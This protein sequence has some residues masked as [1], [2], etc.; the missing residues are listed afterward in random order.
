MISTQYPFAT[1]IETPSAATRGTDRLVPIGRPQTR[2][3]NQAAFD[4]AC[5]ELMRVVE[6]DFTPALVVGVRTGGL[7]VA[8]AM[9]RAA[10]TRPTVLPLTC[11]RPATTLKSCIPGL[12]SI[13]ATMPEP[14][15]N[16]LRQAEHRLSMGR[17]HAAGS[18]HVDM[19]EAALIGAWLADTPSARRV[20]VADDAVDSGMTLA[21]VL[22]ALRTVCPPRVEPRTAVITLTMENPVVTPDYTL[23]R[24]VLCRFPWSFD[25]AR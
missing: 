5:A 23:Y 10:A 14:V 16:T 1:T 24:G 2:T 17:R 12:R 9:A 7:A 11:R 21:A 13:L 25:A 15:L 8:A 4:A 19:A 20:L 22:R 3:L 6:Q 18:A